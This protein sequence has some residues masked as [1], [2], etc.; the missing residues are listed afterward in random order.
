MFIITSTTG[1]GEPPQHAIPFK[2]SIE[3]ALIDG[4]L[5]LKDLKYSVFALGSSLYEKFCYFGLFCDEGLKVL[6]G[7][8]IAPLILGDEQNGQDLQFKKWSKMV[9][10]EACKSFDLEIPQ[11]LVKNWPFN[12]TKKSSYWESLKFKSIN[13]ISGKYF[14]FFNE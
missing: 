8:R 7:Q 14:K 11:H 6:G 9:L 3:D 4:F 1:N 10:E 5:T 13:L 12:N 2:K